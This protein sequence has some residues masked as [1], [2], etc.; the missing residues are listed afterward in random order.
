MPKSKLVL[1]L[2]D[3]CTMYMHTQ[4]IHKIIIHCTCIIERIDRPLVNP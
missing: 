4:S 2:C 1:D 3:L